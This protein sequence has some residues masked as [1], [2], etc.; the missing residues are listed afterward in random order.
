MKLFQTSPF[1]H[2]IV[3][4]LLLGLCG[5]A[6][7]AELPATEPA[8]KTAA[9][10]SNPLPLW[11]PLFDPETEIPTPEMAPPNTTARRIPETCSTA[12]FTQA[13]TAAPGT[14]NNQKA[15]AAPSAETDCKNLDPAWLPLIDRLAE[16]DFDKAAAR[17]LFARLGPSSFT[18]AY[19]AAKVLELHGVPGIGINRDNQLAPIPP[20]NRPVPPERLNIGACKALVAAYADTFKDIQEKHGVPPADI[21]AILLVETGLGG[22]L[23]A[24]TALRALA[25]M[26][27]VDT[28]EKLALGGNARQAARLNRAR[29]Q[30]T[31]SE[32][33][34][35]AY[36]EVK[37]LILYADKLGIDAA[38]IPASMYGAV[39]VCQFMPSNITPYG[40]DG[41]GDGKVDLFTLPD[42]FYSVAR[43]LEAAGR[44]EAVTPKARHAVFYAY[45]HDNGYAAGVLA[46]SERI[47]RGL[48]GKL[49]DSADPL[50]GF[51]MAG[52]RVLDPSLRGRSRYIT[53]K[54]RVTSLESYPTE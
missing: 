50:A 54:G 26:A 1:M 3:C 11:L 28:P 38:V 33:S 48:A 10:D 22:D 9:T 46:A 53:P 13:L 8:A 44:R 52:P 5:S 30:A 41:D 37:S 43:Y 51:F 23:G 12:L 39:G 17:K 35:W 40:C 27:A 32:K 24:D 20:E 4:F 42:V 45:N 47:E 18:P 16:D 6:V 2:R 19:M 36:T 29:L 14:P 21:I 7:A 49:S 15:D 31:L 25:S 34:D